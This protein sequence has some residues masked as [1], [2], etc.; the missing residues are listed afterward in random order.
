MINA[1]AAK[2]S[3]QLPDLSALFSKNMTLPTIAMP[4]I[5]MPNIDLV[6]MVCLH[7]FVVYIHG[8]LKL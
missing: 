5:S 6:R 7:V 3:V 8:F 1:L 4:S 2:P